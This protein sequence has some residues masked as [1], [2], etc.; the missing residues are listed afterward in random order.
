[1]KNLA[2]AAL[3]L[4][5]ASAPAFAAGQRE[6]HLPSNNIGCLYT[7]D[8]GTAVY[9][10]P[11]NLAEISCD[12]VAPRYVRVVL[13]RKRLPI[14]YI[15]VGDPSCCGGSLLRYGQVFR[16]GLFVCRAKTTGLKCTRGAHGFSMSRRRVTTY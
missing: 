8:G 3:I 2:L 9:H 12:R 5:I 4:S 15:H 16:A 11:D 6:F 7:P 1:M 14:K 13:G 10:T